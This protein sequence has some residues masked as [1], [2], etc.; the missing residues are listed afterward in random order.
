MENQ[1]NI[2]ECAICGGKA[3]DK[4]IE[5]I[6]R[7]GKHTAIVNLRAK[8]CSQCGEKYFTV[9]QVRHLEKIAEDL[10]MNRTNDYLKSGITFRVPVN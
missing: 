2:S 4:E 7:G 9:K 10:K 3:A 6:V 1:Y 8:V 5:E